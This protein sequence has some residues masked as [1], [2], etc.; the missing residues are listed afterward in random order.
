MKICLRRAMVLTLIYTLF[1]C[2]ANAVEYESFGK[3]DPFV[4]LAGINLEYKAVG[5]TGEIKTIDD[6]VLQGI[7]VGADGAN[8]AVLNDQVM[9]AGD[10]LDSMR[11]ES[12]SD[13][14]V[15]VTIGDQ[16]YDIRLYEE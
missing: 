9:I 6:V 15:K 8:S 14:L 7:V 1:C 11:V 10:V 2:S 12:I 5:S 16:T 13:T 3:R 4:P